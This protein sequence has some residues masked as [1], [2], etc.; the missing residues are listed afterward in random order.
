MEILKKVFEFLKKFWWLFLSVLA[1]VLGL[2]LKS[3]KIPEDLQD[4]KNEREDLQKE[5][6]KLKEEQKRLEKEAKEIEKEKPFNN[7]DDAVKY[8]N[9]RRR[10]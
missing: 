2:L 9:S 6:D 3:Y 7:V 5:E 4:L 8:I 10:K 1:F